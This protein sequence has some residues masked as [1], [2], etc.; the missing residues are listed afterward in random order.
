MY[1]SM[2]KIRLAV[3]GTATLA[4]FAGSALSVSAL[5][6]GISASATASTTGASA[7]VA[8]ALSK[9]ITKADADISA[10]ITA[11][12]DLNTRVQALKNV[13]TAEKTS[14][15]SQVQ[16]NITGLTALQTQ[17][18][19]DT[20]AAAARTD[21]ATIFTSFRIYALVVPQGWILASADRVTTI[22][23]LMTSLAANIETRI[24]ADQSAGKNVSALTAALTDMQTKI[25]DANTQSASA[26]AGVL[27]LVPDQGDKTKAA[28][29]HVAL[30]AAR[31]D[32]K[33]A[34]TD[35]TAARK[36]VTTL[37]Q[38]LK[39][40]D[41]SASTSASTSVTQ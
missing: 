8:A 38:G 15:A 25:T 19:A 10:R 12:N 3:V 31:S 18:D 24:T 7:K 11:L 33:V 37:L 29:N 35:I 13:S 30:V 23:G 36:D 40:L 27:A 5:S 20:T 28:S 6:V 1:M 9:I 16:T 17:I 21:A 4:M 41:G 32:I 34:T 2:N 14:I 22:T 39:S 26:Q